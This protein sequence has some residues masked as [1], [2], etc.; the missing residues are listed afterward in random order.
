MQPRDAYPVINQQ[1]YAGLGSGDHLIQI[2]AIDVNQIVDSTPATVLVRFNYRPY[3]T[4]LTARPSSSPPEADVDILARAEGDTITFFMP[5][6]DTAL[7]ITAL[8]SDRHM[9]PPNQDP[10][11]PNMVVGEE[12]GS[13]APNGYRVFLRTSPIEPSFEMTPPGGAPFV[14]LVDVGEG[15]GSFV[16]TV[17]LRDQTFSNP[18]GGRQSRYLRHI[19]IVRQSP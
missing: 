16:L 11:D 18:N 13:L 17:D 5:P 15:A 3:L 12:T 2:R 1:L 10:F 4:L 7:V 19:R 14:E 9:P 8:G 6:G